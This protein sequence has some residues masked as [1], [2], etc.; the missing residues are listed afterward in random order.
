MQLA[1]TIDAVQMNDLQTALRGLPGRIERN[2]LRAAGRKGAKV[3]GDRIASRTPVA[4]RQTRQSVLPHLRDTTTV[5]QRTYRKPRGASVTYFAVGYGSPLKANAHLVEDGTAQR[6][7]GSKT[8]YADVST[9]KIKTRKGW[10]FKK[11]RRSTGSV[12]KSGVV[13]ANRGTMPAFRPTHKAYSEAQSQARTVMVEEIRRKLNSELK[14]AG[15]RSQAAF[16]NL[17]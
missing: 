5:K 3:V 14:S 7:T 1:L 13:R 8:N 2:V 10:V 4:K 15:K 11:Q 9:K 16:G 12:A 6:F 17:G